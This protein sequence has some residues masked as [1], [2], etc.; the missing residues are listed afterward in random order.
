MSPTA[1]SPASMVEGRKADRRELA[2][3]QLHDG[4]QLLPPRDLQVQFRRQRPVPGTRRRPKGR[5][6]GSLLPERGR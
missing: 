6:P 3:V 1:T 5:R 2:Q 4:G